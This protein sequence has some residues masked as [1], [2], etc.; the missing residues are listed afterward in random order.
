[1]KKVKENYTWGTG[2]FLQLFVIISH[3]TLITS[4]NENLEA[5]NSR[6]KS[7][8]TSSVSSFTWQVSIC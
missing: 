3:E 6:R 4:L 5:F 1:M 8:A 7:L 2:D